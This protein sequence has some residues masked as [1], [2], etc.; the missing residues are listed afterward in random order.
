[1]RS[2]FKIVFRES[3]MTFSAKSEKIRVPFRVINLYM[4]QVK[5]PSRVAHKMYFLNMQ[6][7]KKKIHPKFFLIL[8]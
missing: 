5:A 6:I 2:T 3:S 1:M 4:L 8:A 7:N